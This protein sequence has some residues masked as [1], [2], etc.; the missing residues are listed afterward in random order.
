MQPLKTEQSMEWACRILLTVHLFRIVTG[1]IVYW[2]TEYQLVSPLLPKSI[3]GQISSPYFKASLI[4]ATAF[5]VSLWFYFFKK[6]IVVI[7]ISGV[8]IVL[9]EILVLEFAQ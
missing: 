3:I 2:Q 5:L 7:V 1:Y 9:F 6:R 4:M 8:S